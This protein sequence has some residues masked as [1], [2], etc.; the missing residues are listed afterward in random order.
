MLNQCAGFVSS[1]VPA[2]AADLVV[3]KGI[4]HTIFNNLAQHANMTADMNLSI[5]YLEQA[6]EAAE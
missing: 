4:M 1:K 5:Q 6:L 2:N 3:R